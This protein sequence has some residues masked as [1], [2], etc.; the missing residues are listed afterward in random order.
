MFSSI[1]KRDKNY[2]RLFNE[3]ESQ[4]IYNE[5]EIKK[6]FADQKFIKQLTFTK[7]YLQKQILKSL[8]NYNIEKSI[9]LKLSKLIF[10]AQIL[11]EKALY[12]DFKQTVT[13]G[14]ILSEKYER[15]ELTLRFLE[16]EKIWIY[17]KLYKHEDT[18]AIFKTEEVII[19]KINNLNEYYK[20][21]SS[22]E[23]NY[24]ER[25]IVRSKEDIVFL[26][27]KENSSLLKNENSALSVRAKELRL[28][29]LQLIEDTKVNY[30]KILQY[31]IGRLNLVKNNPFP[32]EGHNLNY[33]HDILFY[34]ILNSIRLNKHKKINSYFKLL[35]DSS[36]ATLN[37]NISYFLIESAYLIL[38]IFINKKWSEGLELIKKIDAGFK[39]YPGMIEYDFELLLYNNFSAI[40]LINERYNDCLKCLNFLLNNPKLKLRPDVEFRARIYFLIAHYELKNYDLLQHL[41]KSTYMYFYKRK[42]LYKTEKLVLAF[43]KKIP[44]LKDEDDFIENLILLKKDMLKLKND[45]YGKKSF[46]YNEYLFWIDKKLNKNKTNY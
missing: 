33:I 37:D 41:I 16:L 28:H 31:S 12:E 21:I 25:G 23:K 30:E 39:K 15:F 34:V 13:F 8:L 44:G 5:T 20:I 24:R 35:K 22:L 26:E 46:S 9:H 6:K 40:Y 11:F 17:R 7:N 4:D 43:L 19:K 1:D 36:R 45:P 32:F 10:K 2:I 18:E 38:E 3:I 29:A 27:H 42:L 14:K